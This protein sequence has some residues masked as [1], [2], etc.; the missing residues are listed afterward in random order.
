MAEYSLLRRRHNQSA[1]EPTPDHSDTAG[2]APGPV[3]HSTATTVNKPA[4]VVPLRP[5][6]SALLVFP[7]TAFEGLC[8]AVKLHRDV[9]VKHGLEVELD[10]RSW[11]RNASATDDEDIAGP[12]DAGFLAHVPVFMRPTVRRL[13]HRAKSTAS[14]SS[15]SLAILLSEDLGIHWGLW[16][17]GLG[18]SIV[19]QFVA[20]TRDAAD[21]A[22]LSLLD[23]AGKAALSGSTTEYDGGAQAAAAAS[24]F[25]AA[26]DSRMVPG[27]WVACGAWAAGLTGID[28]GVAA[29]LGALIALLAVRILADAAASILEATSSAAFVSAEGA[30]A[31]QRRR[32]FVRAIVIQACMLLPVVRRW[33]SPHPQT[34]LA[35]GRPL[36][37]RT[38]QTPRQAP[39]AAARRGRRERPR[40]PRSAQ[41]RQ[42]GFQRGALCCPHH[43]HRLAPRRALLR[44]RPSRCAG[45]DVAREHARLHVLRPRNSG[46]GRRPG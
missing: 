25:K 41:P 33:S 14:Q 44:A 42:R 13:W 24:M 39:P 3:N 20:G 9:T 27:S 17:A 38:S 46:V 31:A 28:P 15:E 34:L 10:M 37:R 40:P 21:V 1:L 43:A 23:A 6:L 4:A 35:A 26:A 22:A 16:L 30:R 5:R 7:R 2:F 18:T 36:P 8:A 11:S 29:L 32:R 12:S 19:R 45:V